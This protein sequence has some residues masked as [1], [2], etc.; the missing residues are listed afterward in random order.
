MVFLMGKLGRYGASDVDVPE[1]LAGG[2]GVMSIGERLF[3]FAAIVLVTLGGCGLYVP[4]KDL[5]SNDTV[6]PGQPSP[7]GKYE[8][9]VVAHIRCE[10]RNGVWN[11]L[12]LGS[13]V[14]W[15]AD[16]GATVTLKMQVE[17]QSALNPSVSVL[18][19]LHNVI[20]PF[21]TG[22]NVTSPQ[23]IAYGFGATGSANA[24]R[25]E[26][27]TFTYS[28]KELIDEAVQDLKQGPLSCEKL[29]DGIMVQGDL[30]IG[31]FIYDK[32][33]LAYIGEVSSRAPSVAPYSTLQE[34]ITFVT[35]LGAS[36]SPSWKFA[37]ILI[38]PTGTLLSATR[39]H[40]NDVLITFGPV[41]VPA[42]KKTPAVLSMQTNQVHFAGQ[43]GGA[44]ASAIVSQ[45]PTP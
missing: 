24:T 8:N 13:N 16:W 20:T 43:I 30:K 12:K 5:L 29:E 28:N 39:T 6:P 37:T 44:T 27:I 41:A 14:Q 23:A 35:A 7:S 40:L 25:L 26:T 19:V 2:D 33:V 22:G 32:A 4:D 34:D 38:N 45:T 15:L 18:K 31:Q 1:R 42:T 10:I 9:R 11:A 17:E 36:F 3:P 21:S